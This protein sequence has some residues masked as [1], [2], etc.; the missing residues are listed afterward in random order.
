MASR[1][2]HP[3]KHDD[4]HELHVDEALKAFLDAHPKIA[5]RLKKAGEAA[6]ARIR[7]IV[8]GTL[9]VEAHPTLTAALEEKVDVSPDLAM[10]DRKASL[11]PPRARP[12][13]APSA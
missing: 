9:E 7:E 11:A 5:A 2:A 4:L 13:A 6:K 12:S 3:I 10:A 8:A 1:T